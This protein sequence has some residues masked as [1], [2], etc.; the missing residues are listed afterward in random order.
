MSDDEVRVLQV[1]GVEVEDV[2]MARWFVRHHLSPI[3]SEDVIRDLELAASELVTNA[4][5]HEA[6]ATVAIGISVAGGRATVTV[7]STSP[8]TALLPDVA[9]WTM[10]APH[11]PVGRGLA[12]VREVAD[13][14]EIEQRGAS[15]T[16]SVH[17]ELK[18]PR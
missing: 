16:I 11:E 14:V 15:L 12:V 18:R 1:P 13:D 17:R 4:W 8:A 9:E 3:V 6:C 10:P 5:A 7:V 2:P